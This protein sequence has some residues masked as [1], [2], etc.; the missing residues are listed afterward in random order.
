MKAPPRHYYV[1]VIEARDTRG[2]KI[3]YVGQSGKTPEERL[4]QHRS[5]CTRYC[6]ACSCKHYIHGSIIGLRYDL[7]QRYNPL[8][9]RPEAERIERLLAR[10][11]RRQGFLVRGGH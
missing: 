3:V 7:F 11:L 9:S 8:R 5:G 2:R 1:Y 4:R 10:K 6:D